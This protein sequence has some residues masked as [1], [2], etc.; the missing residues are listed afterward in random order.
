M[1]PFHPPS[2][3]ERSPDAYGSAIIP[4]IEDYAA[5]HDGIAEEEARAWAAEQREL[6]R[7]GEFYFACIQFCFSA[8]RAG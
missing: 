8:V 4:L 1:C 7:R 2:A 6:G 5:G 3:T